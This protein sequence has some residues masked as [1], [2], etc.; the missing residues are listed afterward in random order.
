ML[1]AKFSKRLATGP[2]ELCWSFPGAERSPKPLNQL[3]IIA[4]PR[5][6]EFSV[7]RSRIMRI[8]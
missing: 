3:P 8:P 1:E 2:Q 5:K 6:S 4:I 7:R